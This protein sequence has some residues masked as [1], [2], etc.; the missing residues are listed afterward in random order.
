MNT[1]I[2]LSLVSILASVAI[3]AGATFAFFSDQGTSSNNIFNSGTLD[4]KLSDVNESN[5][6][7]V[8]GTW[9][10]AS[11]PGDTFTGDLQVKNTGSVAANH[12]ELQVDNAVTEAGSPPGSTST[13]PMDSV[14]EITALDWDSDGNGAVDTN[15][16][17]TVGGGGDKNGNGIIDLDDL[18]KLN[19]DGSIDFDNIAFSAPQGSNHKLTIAG[20]LSPTLTVNEHQGDSVNMTLTVTMNQDTSQ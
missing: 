8:S 15:L 4:M 11:A 10:L 7:S 6:E 19:V 16:L 9:G 1:K 18:E 3:V 17:P 5:E 20:R 2:V 13:I 14:I 12:I